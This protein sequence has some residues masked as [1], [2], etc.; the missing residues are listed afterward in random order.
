M[1]RRSSSR[2]RALPNSRSW[3]TPTVRDKAYFCPYSAE[4][5]QCE[6]P[7]RRRTTPRAHH[8]QGSQHGERRR[9]RCGDWA[10]WRSGQMIPY[11]SEYALHHYHDYNSTIST[12]NI[13]IL[14]ASVRC[15][16]SLIRLAQTSLH[17][18]L[19]V[20]VHDGW[21]HSDH[22]EVNGFQA[23]QG[24]KTECCHPRRRVIRFHHI[25]SQLTQPPHFLHFHCHLHCFRRLEQT[26]SYPLI[27]DVVMRCFSFN[28]PLTFDYT[29]IST[30][31]IASSHH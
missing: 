16:D 22:W 14:P 12:L 27:L 26:V 15:L 25:R 10:S 17:L 3:W 11:P 18:A 21:Q 5:E 7:L 4:C 28:S 1:E 31:V 2:S 20:L 6:V 8:P 9:D 29:S 13:I 24:L 30:H 19:E 23:R